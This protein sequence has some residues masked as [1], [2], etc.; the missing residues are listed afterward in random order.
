M[1]E[2][3]G[4]HHD[5]HGFLKVLQMAYIHNLNLQ[6]ALPPHK[7]AETLD[8]SVIVVVVVI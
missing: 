3:I 8:W 1:Y 7:N 2:I 6:T 4:S 5:V